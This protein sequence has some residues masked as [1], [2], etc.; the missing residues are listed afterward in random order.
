M[1][2]F[3]MTTFNDKPFTDDEL[4]YNKGQ[5]LANYSSRALLI[6]KENYDV[7]L[8]GDIE[9]YDE[10]NEAQEVYAA[11]GTVDIYKAGHHGYDSSNTDSLLSELSP[12]V[13]VV[14]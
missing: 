7:L 4:K 12:K 3:V 6:E 9:S 10:K 11:T 1:G 2:D 13:T 14:T 5:R 8:N